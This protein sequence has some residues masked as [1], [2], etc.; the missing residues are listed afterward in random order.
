MRDIQAAA[1]IVLLALGTLAPRPAA[2]EAPGGIVKTWLI[3]QAK[4]GAGPAVEVRIGDE[5]TPARL[6][7]TDVKG[8]RV[9]A[10]GFELTL[11]WS[12]CGDGEALYRFAAPAMEKAPPDIH[13]AHLRLGIAAG[14]AGEKAFAEGL[15]ALKLKDADAAAG[16]RAELEKPAAP[17]PGNG[18]VAGGGTAIP[19]PDAVAAGMPAPDA[20]D[21]PPAPGTFRD[22]YITGTGKIER[23]AYAAE[24]Q[25]ADLAAIQRRLGPDYD[26]FNKGVKRDD[27]EIHLRHESGEYVWKERGKS[28]VD[29]TGMAGQIFH[30]PFKTDNPG[31]DRMRFCWS[32]HENHGPAKFWHVYQLRPTM[33]E[34]YCKSPDPGVLQPA[35]V[36]A[37]GGKQGLLRPVAT[38][39]SRVSWSNC[40]I[41]VFRSGVIGASGYGNNDD[42][43]PCTRLPP[44]KIPT[45]VALTP[46]NEFALVTVWDVE[47]GKGQLAVVALEA[48][49]L[50]HH[51][52]HYAGLP[53]VGTYTRLKLLGFVDLPDMAAPTAIAAAA[54]VAWWKWTTDVSKERLDT[55][56]V[57]D[58][59]AK[60]ADD[61]HRAATAG[62]AVVL[63]RGENRASFVDLR[64]LFQYFASM[65]FTTPERFDKTKNEGPAP[66]QWPFTFDKAPEARPKV[67][68]TLPFRQ[69]TAVAA[70]FA[71][72]R[73]REYASRCFIA[74]LDGQLIACDV[75]SL[76]APPGAKEAAAPPAVV[77]VGAV[78][79]GRNPTCIYNGRHGGAERDDLVLC[80]RGDREIVWVTPSGK[81]GA[82]TRRL[83][84][85][86]LKDPA[87][88]EV[89]DT[90]GA[91][92]LT[93]ADFKGAR[94][95][96]YLTRPI[97]S[98]GEKLF[99]GLGPDGKADFECTG[100]MEVPGNPFL[101][102]S[103]EVN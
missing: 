63:S 73:S 7:T 43:Y 64:P 36:E 57:R 25:S 23:G 103:A 52:W 71:G 68:Q 26:Y 84:D 12:A 30:V 48:R 90:R 72:G 65:Y 102:S 39:R 60:G 18:T 85:R 42:K 59:W 45:A 100:T 61:G 96:N 20:P 31:V 33:E 86:R 21:A 4:A 14:R 81:G 69:P 88:L 93:V 32:F 95:V 82:V 1:S 41:M 70:G 17:P 16:I 37:A 3:E 62:Y 6:V 54:N 22:R 75:G 9:Q 51:S 56:E 2:A 87:W 94:L 40:G 101:L 44:G 99:G 55:Q 46:N 35:W 15:V 53:N 77:P 27:P 66:D 97:D 67:V 47:R 89:T 98:W 24:C 38:A 91:A 19:R 34:W 28:A 10:K 74:T 92:V 76:N 80:C 11:P 50:A 8:V 5:P 79:V 49:A 13:A 58:R 83:R 29:W 78:A